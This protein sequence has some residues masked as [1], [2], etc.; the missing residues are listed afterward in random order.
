M[1]AHLGT[2][3]AVAASPGPLASTVAANINNS[4]TVWRPVKD[5]ARHSQ[6]QRKN[7]MSHLQQISIPLL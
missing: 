2:D 1:L 4:V 6:T 3:G 7:F 5:D